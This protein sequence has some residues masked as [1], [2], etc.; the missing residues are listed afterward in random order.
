MGSVFGILKVSKKE[1]KAKGIFVGVNHGFVYIHY[2]SQLSV[3]NNSS[4]RITLVYSNI[5]R[6]ITYES[7]DENN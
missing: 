7:I 3:Q 1:Q 6:I 2:K 4:F 5:K